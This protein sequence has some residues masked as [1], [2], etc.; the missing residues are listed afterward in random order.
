MK[1]D[2]I[3]YSLFLEKRI[4]PMMRKVGELL[5]VAHVYEIHINLVKWPLRVEWFFQRKVCK[6]KKG[7]Q[8]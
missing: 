5:T 3:V 1:N 2:E 7:H 4:Y 8:N 6:K